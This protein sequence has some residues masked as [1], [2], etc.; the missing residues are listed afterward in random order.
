MY[1]HGT[2]TRITILPTLLRSRI[3]STRCT[4]LGDILKA[5]DYQIG[6]YIGKMASGCSHKPYVDTYTTT[7]GA[8]V[9]TNGVPKNAGTVS[10]IGP[11]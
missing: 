6:G 3:N 4:L 9:G 8:V 10:T 1:P 7:K 2:V 5:V 11:P